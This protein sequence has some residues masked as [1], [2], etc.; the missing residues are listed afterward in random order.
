MDGGV[1]GEGAAVAAE[2]RRRER[3]RGG[4]DIA[5]K[6]KLFARTLLRT[7]PVGGP[8]LPP[9]PGATCPIREGNPWDP[10]VRANPAQP[11][12]VSRVR[13]PL[14]FPSVSP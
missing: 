1:R 14:P 12:S 11:P 5:R 2:A 6:E 8:R 9:W 4:V 13:S 3:R 10:V 7:Y